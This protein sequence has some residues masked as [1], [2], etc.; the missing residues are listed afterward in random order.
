L[1][2]GFARRTSS[3]RRG[4]VAG[5]FSAEVAHPGAASRSRARSAYRLIPFGW[6]LPGSG[7]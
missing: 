2:A 1:V 6:L 3:A 4:I 7:A 5:G